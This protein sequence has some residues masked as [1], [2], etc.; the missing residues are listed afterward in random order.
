[1]DDKTCNHVTSLEVNRNSPISDLVE[2]ILGGSVEVLKILSELAQIASPIITLGAVIIAFNSFNTNRRHHNENLSEQIW[3]DYEKLAFD[4]PQFAPPTASLN[5]AEQKFG[6]DE[7]GTM[8]VK[9]EWF[10]S[11]MLFACE[12]VLSSYD[13]VQDW[14]NSIRAQLAMHSAYINSERFSRM[15]YM[16]N[17]S[18]DL[19]GIIQDMKPGM[20]YTGGARP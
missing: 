14:N 4:N 6:H 1:M 10:V 2:K 9:Y 8:F 20:A 16:E 15:G 7:D 18:R 11:I 12:K 19:R 17:L 5:I 13:G 3:R